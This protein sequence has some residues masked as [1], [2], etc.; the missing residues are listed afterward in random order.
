MLKSFLA[1][2][3]T[4]LTMSPAGAA[5]VEHLNMVQNQWA[6]F[7]FDGKNAV[8][9]MVNPSSPDGSLSVTYAFSGSRCGD[10]IYWTCM[11]DS[12][13]TNTVYSNYSHNFGEGWFDK[14]NVGSIMLPFSI[15]YS[16]DTWGSLFA[17]FRVTSGSASISQIDDTVPAAV[18]LPAALPMLLAGLGGLGLFARRR[19]KAA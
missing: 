10:N 9:L 3:L 1:I 15:S 14:N 5:T 12:Q 7:E 11:A 4:T 19:R 6:V 17:Y 13:M 16:N 18:P 8:E 2:A